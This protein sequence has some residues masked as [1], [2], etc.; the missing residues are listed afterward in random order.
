MCAVSDLKGPSLYPNTSNKAHNLQARLRTPA[1]GLAFALTHLQRETRN[2][3]DLKAWRKG[4]GIYEL[5]FPRAV[6][7]FMVLFK[8]ANERKMNGNIDKV[9]ANKSEEKGI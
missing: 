2:R 4:I 6:K 5:L 7:D 1:A 3:I 8:V 9:I